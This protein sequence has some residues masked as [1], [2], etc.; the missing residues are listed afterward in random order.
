MN[1]VYRPAIVLCNAY[2][3]TVGK[4]VAQV[5]GGKGYQVI[6]VSHARDAHPH[7]PASDLVITD[8]PNGGKD[9]YS[10]M[11]AT[12]PGTKVIFMVSI[13]HF[14][15]GVPEHAA[16]LHKPF[17]PAHLETLVYDSLPEHL[18]PKKQQ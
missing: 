2:H 11:Q 6:T 8:V 15:E 12:K 4:L 7:I 5:L 16:V 10:A 13:D 18:K 17:T 14:P 1:D 9:L 3:E